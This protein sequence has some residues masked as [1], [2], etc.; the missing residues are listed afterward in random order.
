MQLISPSIHRWFDRIAGLTIIPYRLFVAVTRP[1]QDSRFVLH[2][3]GKL[4][5]FGLVHFRTGY[6][7]RQISVR[8]GDCHQCGTCCNLLFTCPMLTKQ[9]RCFV[10]GSCRPQACKVFLIDQWD[11]EEVNFCSG[12]C[13]Y[14]FDRE[15]SNKIRK[16]GRC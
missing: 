6:V 12:R 16:T 14:R 11:I 5:R 1:L 4:R 10:Y 13:G 3:S 15:D 9:K 7:Q 8:Q 2:S